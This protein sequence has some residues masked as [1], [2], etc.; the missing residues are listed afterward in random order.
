[1][2]TRRL[3]MLAI[4]LAVSVVL[5]IVERTTMQALTQPFALVLG[6]IIGAGGIRL[7]LANVVVLLVLYTYGM[8]DSFSLLMFRIIIVGQLAIGLFSIPFFTSLVGGLIAF[9]LM[10]LFKKLKG[11]SIISV[12]IMGAIGHVIGQILVAVIVFGLIEI[13]VYFPLMLL[14]SIPAGIFTG[15]LTEKLLT[16]LTPVIDQAA[17]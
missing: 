3:T 13:L 17:L 11:F 6:P 2:Q 5:N 1:M 4:L 12:S 14:I 16:Y 8:R 15:K 9:T 10:I 7:G